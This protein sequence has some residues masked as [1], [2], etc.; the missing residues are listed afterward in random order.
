MERKIESTEKKAYNPPQIE[1]ITLD[2]EISLTMESAPA[3]P[4]S[5]SE[6]KEY[7]NNDPFKTN[8]G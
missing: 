4:P 7:F 2:N 6:N 8:V 1:K 3:D 5:W